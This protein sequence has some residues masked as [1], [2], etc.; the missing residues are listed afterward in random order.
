MAYRDFRPVAPDQ[1]DDDDG[2]QD[3]QEAALFKGHVRSQSVDV[4][5]LQDN[6]INDHPAACQQSM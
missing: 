6:D 4:G 3:E 1:R 2:S 5:G